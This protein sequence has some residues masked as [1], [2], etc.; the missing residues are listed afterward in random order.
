MKAVWNGKVI[1]ESDAVIRLEGNCYF[2]LSSVSPQYLKP[3][4]THTLCM[5]KGK[6]SYYT[7]DVDGK[8]NSDA[9]WF[10]PKPTL[11]AKRIRDHV[12]FWNGVEIQQ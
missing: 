3:S 4:D 2:P 6:A 12:A 1:A 11:L 10:Y 5:W 7:L 9:A 8:I